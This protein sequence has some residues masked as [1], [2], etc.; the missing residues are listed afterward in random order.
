M[1]TRRL[2]RTGIDVPV[3]GLGTIQT[4]VQAGAKVLAVEAGGCLLVEREQMLQLA[5]ANGIALV[6]VGER[7]KSPAQL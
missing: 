1:E 3:V 7:L 4:M 2:G 5:D 6:G